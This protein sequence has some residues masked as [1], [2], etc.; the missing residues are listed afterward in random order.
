MIKLLQPRIFVLLFTIFSFFVSIPIFA[1]LSCPA[2]TDMTVNNT[3]GQLN[4]SWPGVSG[5]IAYDV[6]VQFDD[7]TTY[8]GTVLAP[9]IS[10]P[11]SSTVTSA[12]VSIGSVCM[13]GFGKALKRFIIITQ[14]D[15][16]SKGCYPNPEE[17]HQ[18]CDEVETLPASTK[19]SII[20]ENKKCVY[21][22][23][24]GQFVEDYCQDGKRVPTD[25]S[26]VPNK[27]VPNPF[28]NSFGIQFTTKTTIAL[29][30]NLFSS[31]GQLIRPLVDQ[32]RTEAGIHDLRFDASDL[33]AGVYFIRM[34][35]DGENS[36]HK[37]IKIE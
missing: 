3:P 19:V 30:I 9:S 1:Q 13:D 24:A 31:N 25:R 2:T 12:K 10:I 29:S 17:M 5:T 36:V 37:L 15:I 27:I 21:S 18:Y 32:E 7:G 8:N 6:N 14:G 22:I 26:S 33:P 20:I 4:F 23:S 16:N 11:Y 35:I 34:N 28:N